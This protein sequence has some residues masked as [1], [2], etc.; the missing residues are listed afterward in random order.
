[1]I[2]RNN[3][4][5]QKSGPKKGVITKGVF[6]QEESLES[7]K[8]SKFSR[9]SRKWSDSPLFSSVWGLSRISRFSRKWTFLNRPVFPNPTE[10][11]S[12]ILR[13]LRDS[14]HLRSA[15]A[16]GPDLILSEP[17][18]CKH[19]TS[20]WLQSLSLRLRMLVLLRLAT[21]HAETEM[22]K[23]HPITTSDGKPSP[24]F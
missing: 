12:K 19:G 24:Y 18:T 4:R 1:M 7:L 9:I 11:T 20:S 2:S 23:K 8:F 6:S 21:T 15:A 13:V 5:R 10:R 14:A 22:T 16:R 17:I 3:F